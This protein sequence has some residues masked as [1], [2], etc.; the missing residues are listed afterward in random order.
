M[1]LH[2]HLHVLVMQMEL[3][4]LRAGRRSVESDEFREYLLK[5]LSMLKLENDRFRSQNVGY[6]GKKKL[7]NAKFEGDLISSLKGDALIHLQRMNP[8]GNNTVEEN[9]LQLRKQNQDL[10]TTLLLKF[11]ERLLLVFDT[12]RTRTKLSDDAAMVTLKSTLDISDIEGYSSFQKFS[13]KIVRLERNYQLTMGKSLYL[14]QDE[15]QRIFDASIS[16]SGLTSVVV[17]Q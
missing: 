12:V 13:E 5:E 1:F 3:L 7:E 17:T 2:L 4:T 11:S 15:I 16:S 9:L 14:R 8:N 10:P 6:E